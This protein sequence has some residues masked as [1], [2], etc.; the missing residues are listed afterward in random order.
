MDIRDLVLAILWLAVG[1]LAEQASAPAVAQ[2]PS[3]ANG[4]PHVVLERAHDALPAIAEKWQRTRVL[5]HDLVC[6]LGI[7]AMAVVECPE[8]AMLDD[9][10][11]PAAIDLPALDFE[12]IGRRSVEE[13]MR[14]I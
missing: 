5:A 4:I 3:G 13:R 7:I 6:D 2:R 14:S 1:P 10:A 9:A 11:A 8:W 12:D